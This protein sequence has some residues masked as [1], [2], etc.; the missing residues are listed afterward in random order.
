MIGMF[1]NITVKNAYIF[2]GLIVLISFNFSVFTGCSVKKIAVNSVANALTEEGSSV[3][4]SDNDP[5]LVAQALPFA[6]KTMEALL[7]STPRHQKLLIGTCAG[8]VQYS[9]AF[10]LQP[11]DFI[12]YADLEA[13]RTGRER[14]KKLFLRARNYGMKALQIKYPEFWIGIR[15]NNRDVLQKTTKEDVPALYW[16]AV[17]WISAISVSTSDMALVADLPI[18]TTLLERSLKLDE[19]WQQG[20]IHEVFIPFDASRTEAE[21]GGLEAAENHFHRAMELNQGHSVSPMVSYA[22]AICVKRQDREQ[23]VSILEQVM[24]FDVEQYEEYHLSNILA[25]RKASFLLEHIE[26]YFI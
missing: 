11:A 10:V 9:H 16:T 1:N 3:F 19:G 12:E 20:A 6:L 26:D 15:E 21:G 25:Q 17:A 2:A 5:E 23:F 4:A 24:A 13:A 14:A 22:E 8:F 18:V 7:Q